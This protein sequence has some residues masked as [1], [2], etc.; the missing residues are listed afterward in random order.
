M[1]PAVIRHSH[2]QSFNKEIAELQIEI[3]WYR[4]TS[5][6]SL[7]LCCGQYISLRRPTVH[8]DIIP[9]I[10]LSVLKVLY[11][12]NGTPSHNYRHSVICHPTQVNT[13]RLDPSQTCR[14]SIYLP[15]RDGR[16]S[17]PRWPLTYR[18]GLAAGRRS[19]IQ[20]LTRQ[21]TAGSRTSNLLITSPTP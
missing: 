19:P 7:C 10:K 13:P 1:A 15:R 21:W 8:S 20:V 5:S 3:Q 9:S 12:V 6:C 2:P 16:L 18:D 14:Y 17:W 11:A 4:P